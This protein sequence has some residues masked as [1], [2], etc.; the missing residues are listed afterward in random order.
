[1]KKLLSKPAF[2]CAVLF[3]AGSQQ[4]FAADNAK[5]VAVVNG[6]EI[7]EEVFGLYGEKRVGVRPT[8][9]FPADKRKELLE[10]LI[11]RELIYQDAKKMNLDKNEQVLLQIEEQIHNILTRV[12]INQLLEESPPSEAMLKAVYQSQIV[13]PA[14]QEYKARHILLKDVD[15][16]NAV[17]VEL[18]NGASF[19][20]LAKEKST[21][22]SASQGGDLGWFAPNQMVKAFSDATAKLKPGNH[23]TRPVQTRFGWHVIKLEQSR[24]VDPPPYESVE[25]QVMKVAQ[26]KIINDF[27]KKLKSEASIQVK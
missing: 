22:P 19:E 15:A 3:L 13:D 8:E 20:K 11:N 26:N 21:G 17:I 16:A 1:M 25:A 18:N 5:V 12:R 9:G 6:T 27:L 10:E 7:T 4:V 24:K 2:F 14:S 23:S